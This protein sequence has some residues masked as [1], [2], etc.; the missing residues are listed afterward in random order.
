M[1]VGFSH[2]TQDFLVRSGIISLNKANLLGLDDTAVGAIS[3]STVAGIKTALDALVVHE[4]NKNY[5]RQIKNAVQRLSEFQYPMLTPTTPSGSNV[6]TATTGGSL[7]DSTTYYFRISA[8]DQDGNESLASTEGSKATGA[9]GA[10]NDNTI[11][12]KNLTQIVGAASYRVY[13]SDTSDTYTGYQ[14]AAAADIEGSSGFTITALADNVAGTIPTTNSAHSYILSVN[15]IAA[16]VDTGT[17]AALRGKVSSDLNDT[18][19]FNTATDFGE[20]AITG[21]A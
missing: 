3:P 19:S 15:E 14:A 18:S 21:G 17:F 7:D 16:A 13:F 12:L 4:T 2:I 11:T 6:T 5:I 8:I 20:Q 9:A 1:S 10:A